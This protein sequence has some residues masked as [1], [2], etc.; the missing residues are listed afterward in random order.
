MYLFEVM[1]N[2]FII[3]DNFIN[4]SVDTHQNPTT[5]NHDLKL[6]HDEHWHCTS[7]NKYE[8]INVEGD[9]KI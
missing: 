5:S 6:F 8:D 2:N 1:E 7:I 3:Q 9:C 4:I